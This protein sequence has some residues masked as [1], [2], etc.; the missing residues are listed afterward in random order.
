MAEVERA[1]QVAVLGAAAGELVEQFL[2]NT[3]MK[4]QVIGE[5]VAEQQGAK[6][7]RSGDAYGAQEDSDVDGLGKE[8]HIIVQV[9][10]V[11]QDSVVDGPEAVR[12]HQRVGK[13]EEQA[14]PEE[15]R[16]R[17]ERFVCA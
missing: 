2:A 17:D 16:E 7:H 12:E 11:D 14:D 9:Q 4:R 8:S 1:G 10:L 5:R 3:A 15:R 6:R 13:Q